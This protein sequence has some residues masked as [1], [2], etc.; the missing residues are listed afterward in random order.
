[1]SGG[2]ILISA[3]LFLATVS[4]F[5]VVTPARS[6]SYTPIA[7]SATDKSDED[8]EFSNLPP[9]SREMVERVSKKLFG[10]PSTGT[11]PIMNPFE[12]SVR[13]DKSSLYGEDELFDLLTM[14]N[15]ISIE[16]DVDP[17]PGVPS[18]SSLQDLI[19]AAIGEVPDP[20]NGDETPPPPPASAAAA[21][22]LDESTRDRIR[23]VRAIASD[24]DGTLLSSRQTLH[25][26]TR[27]AVKRALELSS[28]EGEDFVF[29][30]AT[31]K[32]RKGALDSLGIEIGTLIA[33]SN[34]P[35]VYIQGLYCVDGDGSV[36]FER[37]LTSEATA[38]AEKVVKKN[39][40]SVVAYDGDNLYT[41]EV[42]DIV[43]HLHEHYGEPMA[44]LL[45]DDAGS[46]RGTP[47][48]LSSHGPLMHKLILMDDDVDLLANTVRPQLELIAE[49]CG[50][51]V[52]QAIPTMLEWIPS[53][54]SKAVGV[55]K[56]CDALGV[57]MG[58]ELLAL[59]DAENDAEMLSLASIGVAMGNACPVAKEAAGF[60]LDYTN[61]E[62][63]AGAGM[64]LFGLAD[65]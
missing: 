62:G 18:P 29:F 21:L 55:A 63:G 52:T 10:D 9:E 50:A 41:T 60:V 2:T 8:S 46:S 54:C 59:G 39:A 13:V 20:T 47:R 14:H 11:P 28:S 22:D 42:S 15:K 31:G 40:I 23:K 53:G 57:D 61:D 7:L 17:D 12:S 65:R 34:V 44:E 27:M 38:A 49:E 45:P 32:S 35:G 56:V 1:M 26:R 4:A 64:E 58:E 48:S 24:I 3:T 36:I 30:P 16:D 51:S 43:R 6:V 5:H 25:P 37:K 19:N 33:T